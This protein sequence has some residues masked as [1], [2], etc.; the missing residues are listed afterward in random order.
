MKRLTAILALCL[1][2]TFYF[3]MYLLDSLST[4]AHTIRAMNEYQLQ[5]EKSI[6]QIRLSNDRLAAQ[7]EVLVLQTRTLKQAFPKLQKEIQSLDVKLSRAKSYSSN[8]IEVEVPIR[9]PISDSV[10]GDSISSKSFEY[11]DDYFTIKGEI[12]KDSLL[13]HF[14]YIDTL[15]QVIFYG[16]RRRPWLWI[17]SKRKLMQRVSLG[18][19]NAKII[20]SEHLEVEK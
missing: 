16:K 8:V 19:P 14:H 4:K 15:K 10:S 12:E 1:I 17:F 13:C 6:E 20:Y 3:S 2:G 7:N 5:A 11:K 9:V 18:S